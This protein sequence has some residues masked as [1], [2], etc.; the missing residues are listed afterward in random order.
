MQKGT[1]PLKYKQATIHY[2]TWTKSLKGVHILTKCSL[3]ESCVGLGTIS[4]S[5]AFSFGQFLG[6]MF[7]FKNWDCSLTINNNFL[8]VVNPIFINVILID[9][10]GVID[11]L[12]KIS[13]F[14]KRS[15]LSD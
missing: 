11:F 2:R 15:G 13:G 10:Y 3:S 7:A 8:S 12:V 14:N 4:S 1:I 5:S 9:F 6:L